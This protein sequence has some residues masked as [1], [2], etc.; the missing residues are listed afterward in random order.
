MPPGL[1]GS[2]G[3]SWLAGADAVR[4]S[5]PVGR[6]R[7]VSARP[8]AEVLGGG[9]PRASPLEHDGQHAQREHHQ[10]DDRGHGQARRGEQ[11]HDRAEHA[12][13]DVH[14]SH[15]TAP[16]GVAATGAQL[17]NVLR[18]CRVHCFTRRNRGRGSI[19]TATISQC[20]AG[21]AHTVSRPPSSPFTTTRATACGV[22]DSGAGASPRVMRV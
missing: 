20:R 11:D 16:A 22:V 10:R 18:L 14:P 2:A 5:A 17:R 1:T 6:R 8:S 7:A 4:L 15:V 3:S 13:A 21:G 19:L 12:Q 9:A